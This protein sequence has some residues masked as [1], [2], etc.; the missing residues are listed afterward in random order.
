[1]FLSER[2]EFLSA[3]CLAAGKKL[4]YS[5]R[6]E[7]VEIILVSSLES[8]PYSSV[9]PPAAQSVYRCAAPLLVNRLII[10]TTIIILK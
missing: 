4:D 2:R 1:M 6:L 5:S 9:I 3:P 10:I 7:V 8:H